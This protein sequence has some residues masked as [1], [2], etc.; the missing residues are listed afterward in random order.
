MKKLRVAMIPVDEAMAKT[1]RWNHMP[2]D[3]LVAAL[4]QKAKG[5]VLRVDRPALASQEQV[6]EDPLFF[7]VTF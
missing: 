4:N 6:V 7:E 5:G 3:V 1:K 2:F